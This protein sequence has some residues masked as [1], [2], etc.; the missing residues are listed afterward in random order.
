MAYSPC[1]LV[2][3]AVALGR[4]SA[5]RH[6]I[7]LLNLDLAIH[8]SHRFAQSAVASLAVSP[9]SVDLTALGGW[10]RLPV[11]AE[12]ALGRWRFCF[13]A[14]W[15]PDVA[16]RSAATVPA[17]V[18]AVVSGSRPSRPW[19]KA[20]STLRLSRWLSNRRCSG[21]VIVPGPAGGRLTPLDLR[22]VSETAGERAGGTRFFAYLHEVCFRR[23][24]WH[25][26]F[27]LATLARSN[28]PLFHSQPG[29]GR[30]LFDSKR[31]T[32]RRDA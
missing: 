17:E 14:G 3:D 25:V 2:T 5:C 1:R 16:A 7:F 22:S 10:R 15:W 8:A 6:R 30:K 31:T 19:V 20:S 24:S 26:A 28:R 4:S 21:I 13:W 18:G 9:V 23:E 11:G 29:T 27:V 12:S 32:H